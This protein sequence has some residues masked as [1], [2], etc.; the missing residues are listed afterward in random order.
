MTQ[1]L[2]GRLIQAVLVV[3]GVTLIA[4]VIMHLSGDPVELMLPI[5]APAEQIE[6]V[7]VA[8]GMDQPLPIQYLR[9]L[10][11]VARLDFGRSLTFRTPNLPLV[12]ERIPATA[13]LAALAVLIGVAVGI[14]LGV[15][16]ARRPRS[17]IDYTCMLVALAGQSLPSF[18][19]GLMLVILF[20]VN[21][22]W[23][24]AGGALTPMHYVLPVTVMSVIPLARVARL[25]RGSMLDVLGED[26]VRTAYG[27]GLSETRVLF[28]HALINALRPVLTD[29]AML[30][31]RLVGGAIVIESVFAWPGLG[32]LLVTGLSRRDFPLVQTIVLVMAIGF[33]G[34]N[35]IVDILYGVLDPRVSRER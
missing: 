11:G 2:L 18:W 30:L 15:A 19:L 9:W 10:W 12:L 28:R 5:G 32:H 27:K 22:G 21:L 1:F 13:T 31:G 7:R 26:Y 8:L 33:V 14:P 3:V 20:S 24:P 23:L 34:L 16:A 25:V 17:W 4:F 29:A 6:E 35:T